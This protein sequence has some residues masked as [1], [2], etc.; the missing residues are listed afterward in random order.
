MGVKYLAQYLENHPTLKHTEILQWH[1][2]KINDEQK[3]NTQNIIVWDCLGWMRRLYRCKDVHSKLLFDFKKLNI[4]C[5][6]I[7]DTFNRFGF[8]LVAFID[9]YF[10]VDKFTE[11]RRRKHQSLSKIR[12]NIKLIKQMHEINNNDDINKDNKAKQ[13]Q[14]LIKKL[15]FVPSSGY[16]N[17]IE[18]ALKSNGIAVYRGSGEHDIDKDIAQFVIDHKEEVY[19]ILSVDTDYF[20][21]DNLPKDIRL[22]TQFR[23]KTV[24]LKQ[25]KEEKK[26][27]ENDTNQNGGKSK[28]VRF[29]DRKLEQQTLTLTYFN[30][31]EL[32]NKLGLN[33]HNQ[34]LQL[35]C[36][37]G[38]DF[39]RK[40]DRDVILRR[41]GVDTNL[42]QNFDPVWV[43]KQK[44]DDDEDE[45]G[46][47]LCC[48]S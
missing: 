41:C 30:P 21:F 36:L 34:Q 39:I 23:S 28:R 31:H 40:R 15:D 38:N 45:F 3:N 48:L 8:K 17:Y 13:R 16:S 29:K 2:N 42:Q 47:N 18:Q 32:W 24:I 7:I 19:G 10:C 33:I 5:R 22:I 12:K 11:K 6:N 14:S 27:D 46:M 43:P 44:D 1:H 37:C 35:I 4:E 26:S 20:G 9:A 25:E